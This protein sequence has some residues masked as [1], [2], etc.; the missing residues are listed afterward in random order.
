MHKGN[1]I[2]V[3]DVLL[4]ITLNT[5]FEVTITM[6][7]YQLVALLGATLALANPLGTTWHTS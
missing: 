6:K 5:S 4:A 7:V 3:V 2:L 1:L